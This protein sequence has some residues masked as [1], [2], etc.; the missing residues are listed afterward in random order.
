MN[1]EE[2]KRVI[3]SQH[4]SLKTEHIVERDILQDFSKDFESHFITVVSGIRRCG[5]STLIRHIRMNSREKDYFINFDDHRLI[6]FTVE[7][8][9]RLYETFLELYEPQKTLYFDEIQNIPGWEKFVRRLYDEGNKIFI[10]GSNAQ[11]LSSEMGT[12]LTGRSVKT[13]LFPFSFTEFLRFKGIE[14]DEKSFYSEMQRA[15]IKKA[16]EEYAG[17][18]GFPEFLKTPNTNYLQNIYENILYKDV[19]VRHKIRNERTLAELSHF[20]MSNI[21]REFR[22]TSLKNSLGLSNAITV[23][24]YIAY[25]ENSYLLFSINKFD[26]SLK[27]QLTN[28]KRVY[29]IDIALTNAISFAFS[30]NTGRKLENIVFL[31]LKRIGYEIFYHRRK[32]ECDFLL[33]RKGRI[34]GAIQVSADLHTDKTRDREMNGLKEAMEDHKLNKGYIISMDEEETYRTNDKTIEIMPAWKW[35]LTRHGKEIR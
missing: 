32:Y 30:E 2:L 18:G 33:R 4:E 29:A 3:V 27:K 5:K 8:F 14:T 35:L 9:V 17:A 23:K 22:Y 25:L 20:L 26:Y 11:M 12:H 7:D 19:I 16:F 24:E 28:P 15:G 34:A 10:T 31:Q 6:K 1:R 13:E 21:A